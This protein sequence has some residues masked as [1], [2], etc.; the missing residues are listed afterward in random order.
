M[1]SQ[2][3]L[4][5]NI[6]VHRHLTSD[7][8]LYSY[9]RAKLQRRGQLLNYSSPNL[10]SYNSATHMKQIS[11]RSFNGKFRILCYSFNRDNFSYSYKKVKF[12]R[13]DLK[14]NSVATRSPNNTTKYLKAWNVLSKRT[15]FWLFQVMF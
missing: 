14:Q 6:T 10:A 3:E 1:K 7:H 13:L 4:K 12:K 5:M 15:K 2:V 8:S 9:N 11:M